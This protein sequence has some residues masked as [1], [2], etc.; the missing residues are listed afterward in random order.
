MAYFTECRTAEE[1]KKEYHKQAR[2]LHPDNGGDAEAFKAMQA[3]FA[4]AFDRVKNIHTNAKGETYEKT[5][6][7]ATS[8]TAGEFMEI[9][10]ALLRLDGLEV[11]MCGSWVWV[12]GNT[13]DHKDALKAMGCKW[14]AN[15]KMWY[16]QRDGKRKFHKK[17]WSMA[18]IR[19]VYGSQRYGRGTDPDLLPEH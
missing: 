4:K 6:D 16:Y 15:K 9:I 2:R 18:E 1:I 17:A 11:E 12:G 5:G 7:Y 13:K 10:D 19:G 3:E 8:E 14:S